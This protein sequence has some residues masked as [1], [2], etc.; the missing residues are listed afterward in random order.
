MNRNARGVH[1]CRFGGSKEFEPFSRTPLHLHHMGD[2]MNSSWMSGIERQRAT[3]Y[4]FGAAILAV[5]LEAESVHSKHACVAG[6][7]RLPFGQ[8][9]GDAIT[10]HAPLAEPEVERMRS[11][12]RKNVARPVDDY[13]AIT[14]NRV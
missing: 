7:R 11:D 14:F 12:K 10:Q 9:L 4:F 5:L 1:P 2:D 13:G 6:K 3:R 8:H